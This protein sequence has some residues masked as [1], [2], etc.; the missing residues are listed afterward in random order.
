MV[1]VE[2]LVEWSLA[3]ET[4]VLGENLPQC[5]FVHHKP[6][7]PQ[8]EASDQPLELSRSLWVWHTLIM[9]TVDTKICIKESI[10]VFL[11]PNPEA[12]LGQQYDPIYSVRRNL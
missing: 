6:G 7:P 11:T 5:H 2:K 12:V 10:R 9:F 3:G 8:W 4:E 1:I